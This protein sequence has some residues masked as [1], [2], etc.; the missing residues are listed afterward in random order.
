[1]WI[2]IRRLSMLATCS[3]RSSAFRMPVEVQ[4]HQ[5]RAVR[6]AAGRVDEPGH[7]LDAQDLREPTRRLGVRRVIEQIAA[8]QR[9]HEEE[10]QGGNVQTHSQRAH[11][12]LVQ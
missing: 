11:L 3:E 5:H 8:L 6:Q 1:M 2:S 10:P 9:L 7:L 12:P 4:D